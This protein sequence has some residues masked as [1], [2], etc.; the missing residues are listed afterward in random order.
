MKRIPITPAPESELSAAVRFREGRFNSTFL[1][2]AAAAFPA[3]GLLVGMLYVFMLDEAAWNIP[4]AAG[5]FGVFSV[6]PLALLYYNH[7]YYEVSPQHFAYYPWRGRARV[8]PWHEVGAVHISPTDI[9]VTNGHKTRIRVWPT[10][11]RFEELVSL[12]LGH[13]VKA[14]KQ[15]LLVKNNEQK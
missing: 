4:A 9:T 5:G 6:I 12:L 3:I 10:I 11:P 7:C 14:G 15:D 13:L 2:W 1:V 8:I